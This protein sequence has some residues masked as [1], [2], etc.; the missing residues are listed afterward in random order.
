ML[1]EKYF[2]EDP[3]TCLLKLRQLSELL[4]QLVAA[5]TGQLVAPEETQFD[6]LRRLQ[7]SGILTREIAQLFGEVRRTGNAANHT[8]EGDHR[9]ALSALK[10]TWQLS[11]WFHRT[12]K[13]ASFKSGPF[14]PPIPPE[15]ESEEL[16]AEMA[17]LS[18]TLQE[19][20]ATHH[21]TAERLEATEAKL[22]EAKNEQVF[23]EQMA[24]ETEQAKAA[25]EK[26]LAEQQTVAAAQPKSTLVQ[27]IAAANTAASAVQ[28]DEA[29][30]RKLI[31]QQ[32]R[33]AGW[34]AD[35]QN[36]KFNKGARPE[37]GR[38]LAIAEWPTESGPADYVLFAGLMPIAV[39]EAKR[40][41]LDVS[42]SLQQAKRY[43]RIFT[44]SQETIL[45]GENWG[46]E[47][48]YRVPFAFSSNGRPYLRQLS[49]KSGIWFC[50]LRCADNLGHV[51]DGW[52]VYLGRI[53]H[54]AQTR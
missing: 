2:A 53:D 50:D 8:L 29:D 22:R 10:I 44:P 20:Q 14:I 15:D 30:T 26:R 24:A 6:L 52:L 21:E 5:R 9:G 41:D 12:F 33:Q 13:D 27:F 31:D 7:D 1:A 36:I 35:S 49:T 39:A 45:S 51:L 54:A 40:K 37:K 19:Y 46:G 16:R 25:L 23:W 47:A 43:S 17:R 3:N 48:A 11:L 38:N 32:L 42:G 18:K 28:L 34:E 4:A